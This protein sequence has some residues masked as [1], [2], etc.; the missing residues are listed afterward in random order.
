MQ[1]FKT[2]DYEMSTNSNRKACKGK[3][4]LEESK[5]MLCAV[6]LFFVI[7][8]FLR[9]QAITYKLLNFSHLQ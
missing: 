7:L 3:L 5:I 8:S 1:N 2:F 6:C 9:P 4:L